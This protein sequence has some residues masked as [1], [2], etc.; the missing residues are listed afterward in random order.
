RN[1]IRNKSFSLINILGLAVSMSVCL[2]IIMIGLDQYSY[3][4]YHS[5]KDRIYRI[6]TTHYQENNGEKASSA[7]P[8]AEK[9]KG[10]YPA[11]EEA[12]AINSEIG[13]DV[14]F[15]DRF[16]T[17]GGYFAD[18]AL[19]KIMD[20]NFKEG[21]PKTALNEPFSLVITTDMAEILFGEQPAL[22]KTVA[23]HDKD[24][25]ATDIEEGNNV[26]DFGY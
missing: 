22:G 12:A 18:G 7:L 20:F 14:I 15:E 5:K 3:D 23:F 24:M 11:I 17:G 25:R 21:D 26:T 10:E 19:F 1:L 8:L 13:G 2:L 16:A 4:T 6:H 9:L